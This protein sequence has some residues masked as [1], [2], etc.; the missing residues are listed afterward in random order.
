MRFACL[1]MLAISGCAAT[2]AGADGSTTDGGMS[3][4]DAGTSGPECSEARPCPGAF[5]CAA[6]GGVPTCVPDPDPPPPGDGTDCSPCPAPGECRDGTC[7]QPSPTGDFCEFDGVCPA[8]PP[9][10]LC[11]AGRCTVD[12]RVPIPCSSDDMCPTGLHCG[13]SGVCQCSFTTDCPA[14]LTCVG[15]MCTPGDL[16]V[17][18]DECD[19]TEVCDPGGATDDGCRSRT[20]CEIAHPNLSGEWQMRSV[21]R[22]RD[23]LPEWLS[24]FLDAIDGPLRFL[25]G[26]DCSGVDWGLPGTIE[27]SICDIVVGYVSEYLP[28]WAY[29]VFRAITSLNTVL[30]VWYVDETMTLEAS[31]PVG[32]D[33]SG[34][35]Y[36]GTH[37]WN[38]LTFYSRDM[39]IVA[40]PDT[41]GD[42]RFA[43]SPFNASA[44]CGTFHIDRHDVHVSI[45][46]I[47]AWVVDTLVYELSDHM[48]TSLSDALGQLA[49]SACMTIG[50]AA[51]D[52]QSGIGDNV[53]NI[54]TGLLTDLIDDA[55]Q[56]L[57]EAR[58]GASPITLRGES[59][60]V[61]GGIGPGDELLSPGTWEGTLLGS[62]FPGEFCAGNA[63]VPPCTFP[64]P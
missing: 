62:E 27:D 13:D 23:A 17:A 20:V 64:P 10:Q 31:G 52:I 24:S 22:V 61:G 29:D 12:P 44:L 57:I 51:E 25:L 40:T 16:C 59:P 11:I 34:D 8:G 15:M 39:A 26:E 36:R 18:D 63:G 60:I 54:C 1:L 38:Q 35:A 6:V 21:L 42:W 37:V 7:I 47:I 50:D 5:I 58:I 30:S 14:G 19:P 45:G 55:I 48:W 49:G 28:P 56:E 2:G 41:V 9:R 46:G 43:P 33:D 4:T 3:N 53:T 32:V